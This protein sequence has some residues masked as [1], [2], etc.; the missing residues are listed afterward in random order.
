MNMTARNALYL[1]G[2]GWLALSALVWLVYV[3]VL[4]RAGSA[5]AWLEQQLLPIFHAFGNSPGNGV[6]ILA[7]PVVV[8]LVARRVL[9]F[10]AQRS[11][12]A[13]DSFTGFAYGL[14]WLAL[15]MLS[16]HLIAS[17]LL[18]LGVH[19]G[20]IFSKLALASNPAWYGPWLVVSLLMT[21][22]PTLG[23]VPLAPSAERRKPICVTLAL[24]FPLSYP[25]IL[26][27][28]VGGGISREGWLPFLA[29]VLPF[30]VCMALGAIATVAAVLRRERLVPLQVAAAFVNFGALYSLM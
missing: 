28:A 5:P 29:I 10:R 11:L 4:H 23:F 8:V 7:A 16:G 20:V 19:G 13:P 21:E 24:L 15:V 3:A 30:I 26:V 27:V 2:F 18:S 1:G 9:L 14:A 25:V 22:I 12:T 17:Q 6:S